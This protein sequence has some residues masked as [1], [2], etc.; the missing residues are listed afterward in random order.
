MSVET[1]QILFSAIVSLSTVSY[2]VLTWKLVSETRRMREFQITP[3]VTI[4]L[5]RGEADPSL[6]YIVFKNIGLGYAKNVKVEIIKDFNYYD[7]DALQ[8][9]NKGII[10]NGLKSFYPKQCY[11]FFITYL[12]DNYEQKISD[13]FIFKISYQDMNNKNFNQEINLSFIELKGVTKTN[14]PDNYLGRIALELSEI[15][16]LLKK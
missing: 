5:D 7:N 14:P 3:D 6:I 12:P 13:N 1:L 4:Y 2:V 16:M 9:K 11:R 8:L 10:K 15:K